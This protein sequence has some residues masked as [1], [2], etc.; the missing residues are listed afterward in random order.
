MVKPDQYCSMSNENIVNFKQ[1]KVSQSNK[2]AATKQLNKKGE[3][4]KTEKV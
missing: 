1:T 2:R 3:K 4:E